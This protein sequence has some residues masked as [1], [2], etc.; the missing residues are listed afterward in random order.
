M[1]L[2][3]Q[4]SFIPLLSKVPATVPAASPAT[5]IAAVPTAQGWQG[6]W[7]KKIS[8]DGEIYLDYL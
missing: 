3:P 4:A 1:I 6:Q 5:L 8:I 2:R 7:L